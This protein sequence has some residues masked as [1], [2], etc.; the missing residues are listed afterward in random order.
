M[1]YPITEKYKNKYRRESTRLAGWDYGSHGLYFI[2]ICTKDK[3][4]YLGEIKERRLATQNLVSLQATE[5]GNIVETYW[6]N[7][8]QHFPFVELDEFVIMPD[9]LHGILFINKPEKTNWE[10]NKFGI[11]SK[12]LSSVVRGFKASVKSYA[13]LNNID[14]AWQAKFY[15]H[16]IRDEKEHSNIRQYIFDNSERWLL[17]YTNP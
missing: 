14:F 4:P 8:P 7:I 2:T 6:Q 17:K 3:I 15:D 11:Q 9:H 13:T 1:H 5:I 16:I 10:P 12:N